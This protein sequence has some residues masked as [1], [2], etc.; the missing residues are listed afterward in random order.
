MDNLYHTDFYRWKEQ[1]KQHLIHKRFDQLDLKRLIEE[2]D[3]MG[4][5][6]RNTLESHLVILLLH[7]LKY[8]YQTYVINPNLFEPKE[9]R[10]WYDSISQARMAISRLI[11]KNP[12]L[13]HEQDDA[14]HESYPD[15]KSGAIREMNKYLLKKYQLNEQSYPDTCPWS[16]DQIMQED[17]LP[18]A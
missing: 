4:R 15:A 3:D 1:Q 17:W 12:S 14:V 10:S 11:R 16:F 18:E 2:V 6:E 13:Q 8:Q 7:L 5:S 9:F